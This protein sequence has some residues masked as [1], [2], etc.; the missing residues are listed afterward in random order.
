[1]HSLRVLEAHLRV[2]VGLE[3]SFRLSIEDDL[4]E[5]GWVN[6]GLVGLHLCEDGLICKLVLEYTLASSDCTSV[7]TIL[8]QLLEQPLDHLDKR[9]VVTSY[10]L[11]RENSEWTLHLLQRSDNF[12]SKLDFLTSSKIIFE[13]EVNV[14]SRTGD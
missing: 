14:V 1:M 10:D 2:L 3:H 6:F 5:L 11:M 8:L 4:L 13:L 12:L 9:I 7:V